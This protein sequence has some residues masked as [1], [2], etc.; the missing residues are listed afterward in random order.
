MK[1]TITQL[2]D[3][4]I[5]NRHT[6]NEQ[7]SFNDQAIYSNSSNPL[8]N[9][10][11]NNENEATN[12]IYKTIN[13]LKGSKCLMIKGD[14][15]LKKQVLFKSE[16]SCENNEVGEYINDIII[17]K[18]I[19]TFEDPE[20][21]RDI[22]QQNLD[23]QDK[24]NNNQ[25]K[26]ENII[27]DNKTKSH[28]LIIK[29]HQT[30]PN[31]LPHKII[32]QQQFD[33]NLIQLN[34]NSKLNE[35]GFR[36]CISK[37]GDDLTNPLDNNNEI[38]FDLKYDSTKLNDTYVS[39]NFTNNNPHDNDKENNTI[40]N[41]YN[42]RTNND[43]NLNR[44]DNERNSTN[45]KQNRQSH[46]CHDINNIDKFGTSSVTNTLLNTHHLEEETVKNILSMKRVGDQKKMK[47]DNK[48]VIEN[49]NDN[50]I[51]NK[52]EILSAHV[53]KNK[54]FSNIDMDSNKNIERIISLKDKINNLEIN[55]MENKLDLKSGRND[56]KKDN[57]NLCN[58]NYS[59][60]MEFSNNSVE[61]LHKI[62]FD[63]NFSKF[64][65][66]RSELEINSFKN[67]TVIE[68]KNT[69][70]IHNSLHNLFKMEPSRPREYN[71]PLIALDTSQTHEENEYLQPSNKYRKLECNLKDD[72]VINNIKFSNNDIKTTNLHEYYLKNEKSTPC[73]N[74][75]NSKLFN[76]NKNESSVEALKRMLRQD[77]PIIRHADQD[78]IYWKQDH[79]RNKEIDHSQRMNSQDMFKRDRYGDIIYPT[80][81][82]NIFRNKKLN[83]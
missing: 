67:N 46:S 16:R 32:I 14:L 71:N 78:L 51:L 6:S 7:L 40:I 63:G 73:F 55:S 43:Y 56:S 3:S 1:D 74:T 39:N 59:E 72:S 62:K 69:L 27:S 76:N 20:F 19:L 26:F 66:I 53:S 33:K 52:I 82:I 5:I 8:R 28:N 4:K 81:Y 24:S 75:N 30:N 49:K 42:K 57:D 47:G 41:F 35:K 77:K 36:T 83:D 64:T 25:I 68:N 45:I 37:H 79:Q 29:H 65:R 60:V 12:F 50:Q 10:S 21:P 61:E 31:E 9:D 44:V 15:E 34:E 58:L 23:Y 17:N 38:K 18:N 13:K 80:N 48:N 2:K 54:N 11:D 70:K 22:M